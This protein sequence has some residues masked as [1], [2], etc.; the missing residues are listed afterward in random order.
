LL[1]KDKK[2]E[3]CPRRGMLKKQATVALAEEKGKWGRVKGIFATVARRVGA[4][5]S[6]NFPT[7]QKKTENLIEGTFGKLRWENTM[8]DITSLGL[9]GAWGQT[10]TAK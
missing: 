8:W 1:K 7:F 4:G 9:S 2:K 6:S 10:P 5:G 3:P